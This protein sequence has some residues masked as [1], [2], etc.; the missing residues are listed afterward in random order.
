M[1]LYLLVNQICNLKCKFCIRGTNKLQEINIKYLEKIIAVNDF[2]KYTLIITG[3]EPSISSNLIKIVEICNGKFQK[4]CINTNGVNGE[5]IDKLNQLDIHVQISIDGTAKVHNDIR[6]DGK[7]IFSKII[8]NVQKLRDKKIPYSISTTVDKYNY[9]NIYDLVEYMPLFEDMKYWKVS[10]TLPFGCASVESIIS[11]DE[12]N[13]LVDYIL[14]HAVVR[15]KIKKLFSFELLDKYINDGGKAPSITKN[16][17]DV[18]NKIYVYPDF[19]V[20]PCTCLTDF[21]IGNLL[22]RNLK[23]II[24]SNEARIFSEYKVRDDSECAKCKVSA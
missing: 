23:D 17:G 24:E 10:S 4:I 1:Q 11:V 19:T 21:P 13:D 9:H 6:G 14:D 2:S 3:G 15:V 5:W 8:F 20:Y 12:W 18:K 7:D 16:C 22:N